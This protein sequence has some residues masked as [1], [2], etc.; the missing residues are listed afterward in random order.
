MIDLDVNPTSREIRV[1]GGLWLGFFALLSLVAWWRPEGLVGAAIIL[2]TAWLVSLV[3][4]RSM[5]LPMRLSGIL[6]PALFGAIGLAVQSGMSLRTVLGVLAGIGVLG[7]VGIWVWPELGRAIYVGWMRAA[8]PIGWTITHVV[9]AL[10]YYVVLTPIGL[11][12]R[13]SGRDPMHRRLEPAA[14]SYWI[15]RRNTE[16]RGRYFRQF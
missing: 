11:L 8:A 6:L 1:F 2:G 10:V 7:A 12:M 5:P 9:L 16:D 13:L 3:L 4:N 15:E 14:E